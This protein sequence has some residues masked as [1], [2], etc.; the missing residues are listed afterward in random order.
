[1]S[2]TVVPDRGEI[3]SIL[4]EV[5]NRSPETIGEEID[6]LELMRL[7]YELEHRYDIQLEL[8][9]DELAQMSTVS[10]A[11]EVIRAAAARDRS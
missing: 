7:V 8:D 4:A 11:A 5:T 3:V 6:S 10:G 9:D 1:M 2:G